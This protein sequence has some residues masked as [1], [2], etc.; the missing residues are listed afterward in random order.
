MSGYIGGSS[1]IRGG[2]FSSYDLAEGVRIPKAK[3]RSAR[4]L[5]KASKK[6]APKIKKQRSSGNT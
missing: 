6:N 2:Q 4:K 1:I 3:K 5:S